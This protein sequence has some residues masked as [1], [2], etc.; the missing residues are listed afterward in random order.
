MLIFHRNYIMY[1]RCVGVIISRENFVIN[2]QLAE[3]EH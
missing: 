3:I 2:F 1:N